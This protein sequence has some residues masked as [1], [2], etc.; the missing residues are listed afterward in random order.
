MQAPAPQM[1]FVERRTMTQ[2]TT[3]D[4]IK[5]AK[6]RAKKLRIYLAAQGLMISHSQSLEATAQA[7]GFKDWNTYVARFGMAKAAFVAPALK[8]DNNSYPLQVGDP[9]SG[10]YRS[11]TFKGILLGLEQTITKGVWRAKMQFDKPVKLPSAEA[12]NLTRQRV[13]CL[14]N[15]NGM[16]VNLKGRPDGQTVIDMP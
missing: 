5:F 16:S 3:P 2:I 1:P 6:S 13:R 11:C 9:I 12:L 8:T 15:A 7:E 4:L 14:L 10:T